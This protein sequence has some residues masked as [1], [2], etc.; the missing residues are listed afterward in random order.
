LLNQ[1]WRKMKVVLC[2]AYI[3]TLMGLKAN[4]PKLL[5]F[6]FDARSD[7]CLSILVPV[8]C[9]PVYSC[10]YDLLPCLFLYLWFAY[11]S[12]CTC[13][14][15][16]CLFL[17]LWSVY[18][19]ILVPVISLPVYSF[20]CDLLTCLFLYLWFASLSI[21]VPVICLPVCSRTCDLLT[22]L[23]LYLCSA[24]L[25]VLPVHR[26][27]PTVLCCSENNVK[28]QHLRVAN[29]PVWTAWTWVFNPVRTLPSCLFSRYVALCTNCLWEGPWRL[30]HDRLPSFGFA[31]PPRH[32]SR[33]LVYL[34]QWLLKFL[35]TD[36]QK[37]NHSII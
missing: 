37:T 28:G 11:L 13:D 30:V 29:I 22:C 35:L 25:S 32:K 9:L 12:S 23:F 5:W 15:L 24:Y 36:E 33:W 17:Y 6:E 7:V 31:L 27:V 18:L 26:L 21:L 3:L 1:T 2:P 34:K 20:T 16:T 4:D 10:T 19:S 14:L 8:I